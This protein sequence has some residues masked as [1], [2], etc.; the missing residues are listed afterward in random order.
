[1]INILKDKLTKHRAKRFRLRTIFKTLRTMQQFQYWSDLVLLNTIVNCLDDLNLTYSKSEIYASFK[2]VDRSDYYP[3]TK[4]V[5]IKDLIKNATKT[6]VFPTT[7][8]DIYPPLS[9][10]ETEFN[11]PELD[12][13]GNNIT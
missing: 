7:Q 12:N 11:T 1:M 9:I 10:C 2:L 3:G 8:D 5:L 4:K 6:S 13:H